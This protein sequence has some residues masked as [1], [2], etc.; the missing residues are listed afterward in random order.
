VLARAFGSYAKD[1]KIPLLWFY[2]DNDSYW[3]KPVWE[4]MFGHSAG[5]EIWQPEVDKFLAEIGMPAQIVLPR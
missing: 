2:G 1:T 4:N 3:P 5:A